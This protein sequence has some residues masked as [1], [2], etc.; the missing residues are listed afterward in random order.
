MK[1]DT[2]GKEVK[3]VRRV[4]IDADYDRSLSRA[5]YNCPECY[6]AKESA[7]LKRRSGNDTVSG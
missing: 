3:E 4:V 5:L 1:C 2:C 6:A 7:R